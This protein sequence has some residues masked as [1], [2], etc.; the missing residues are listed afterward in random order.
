MCPRA[1]FKVEMMQTETQVCPTWTQVFAQCWGKSGV[2][3]NSGLHKG[4]QFLLGAWSHYDRPDIELHDSVL[5]LFSLLAL[6]QAEESYLLSPAQ[7]C[8]RGDRS[9]QLPGPAQ[10]SSAVCGY[11]SGVGVMALCPMLGFTTAGLVLDFTSYAW[12][13]W[14][15][16]SYVE[17]CRQL[18]SSIPF[19][20]LL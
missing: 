10:S 16:R 19:F 3:V 7:V 9:N 20:V 14:S 1:Q 5:C 6:Q 18:P 15:W 2:S 17:W 13:A 11:W 12:A 8:R 4:C